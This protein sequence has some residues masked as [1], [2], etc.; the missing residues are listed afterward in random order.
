MFI[1]KK[2]PWNEEYF[3]RGSEQ[4]NNLKSWEGCQST[5]RSP[6]VFSQPLKGFLFT[7]KK[8]NTHLLFVKILFVFRLIRLDCISPKQ[9]HK[10]DTSVP[11]TRAKNSDAC[12][13]VY[14]IADRTSFRAAEEALIALQAVSNN[15][16]RNSFED[17]NKDQDNVP[18]IDTS[19]LSIPVVLLGNKKDLGHLRQVS[20]FKLAKS[21]KRTSRINRE[22]PCKTNSRRRSSGCWKSC[23]F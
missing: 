23:H 17:D 8:R 18:P 13:V 4:S 12:V 20:Y 19:S 15:S 5:R 14:S 16:Q 1:I 9:T 3:L 6:L 2:S 21:G 22:K 10:E 7:K 11:T